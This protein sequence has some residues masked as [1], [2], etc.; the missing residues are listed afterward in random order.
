VSRKSLKLTR[1]LLLLIFVVGLN[2]LEDP[3]TP[4]TRGGSRQLSAGAAAP[5]YAPLGG[6]PL[7]PYS[8]LPRSWA[9]LESQDPPGGATGPRREGLM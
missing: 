6:D 1:G 4:L 5:R 9:D 8:G 7:R 2:L 3:R